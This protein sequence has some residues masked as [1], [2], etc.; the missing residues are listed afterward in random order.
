MA[1][2]APER[3]T[4]S[5]DTSNVIEQDKLYKEVLY[6]ENQSTKFEWDEFFHFF[7]T[8]MIRLYNKKYDYTQLS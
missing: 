6:F 1:P 4:Y 2:P 8:E 7:A 3:R 5:V